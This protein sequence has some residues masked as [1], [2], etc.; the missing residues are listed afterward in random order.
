VIRE[1]TVFIVGAGASAEYGFPLGGALVSRIIQLLNPNTESRN[2]FERVFEE[3]HLEIFFHRLRMSDSSSIDTFLEGNNPNA[4][5]IG[6]AAIGVAIV[7]AENSALASERIVGQPPT[8][9]WL[10]YV[11]NA[12]RPESTVETLRDNQVAFITF[13]YDR[14]LEYYFTTVIANSFGLSVPRAAEIMKQSVPIVHLHGT[15]EELEFGGFSH[16]RSGIV[17]VA[18]HGIRVVH[19]ALAD[20][21]PAFETA[22]SYLRNA[23]RVVLLGFG[24]HPV[25]ISR[26]RLASM[27]PSES[28]KLVGGAFGL[29]AAEMELAKSRIGRS[30]CTI[31]GPFWKCMEFLRQRVALA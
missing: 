10:G 3:G 9:H 23:E 26:L 4:I 21:D 15:P 11:W 5:Q 12:M 6:K 8:D 31:E 14:V 27:L 29:G 24:Y 7:E 25:N 22:F 2:I 28:C 19:D 20:G 30:S 1:R 17:S 13:N 16:L 18:G